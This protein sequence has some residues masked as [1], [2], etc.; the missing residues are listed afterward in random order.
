MS[1]F[2]EP[3]H[4]V[5]SY[6]TACPRRRGDRV[7]RR[8]LLALLA[9]VATASSTAVLAQNPPKIYR[10]GLLSSAAPLADNS[11]FGAPL[12]RGLAQL[13]YV[14]GRNVALERRAAE[15][16]IDRLPRQVDE[17][18]AS[19]VDVIVAFGYNAALTAKQ[20]TT[21]PVVVVNTGEPVGAGLVESLARRCQDRLHC[22]GQSLGERLHR[23]LQCPSARRAA[24]W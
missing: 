14:Q 9:S 17:L 6:R 18:V 15:G 10:V 4:A 1:Q 24:Q 23:E 22:T 8:A 19:K 12:I 2:F 21:V 5:P 20:Q 7:R 13:G 16:H 11:L 3:G